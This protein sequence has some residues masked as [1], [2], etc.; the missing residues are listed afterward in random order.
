MG[1]SS[2]AEVTVL[3]VGCLRFTMEQ[4]GGLDVTLTVCCEGK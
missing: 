3:C 1:S 4:N 2:L